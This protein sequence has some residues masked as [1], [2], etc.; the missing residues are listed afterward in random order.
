MTNKTF[1]YL[2]LILFFVSTNV[3]SHAPSQ[4]TDLWHKNSFQAVGVYKVLGK[5]IPIEFKYASSS[6][7]I[8]VGFNDDGNHSSLFL[9][10]KKLQPEG[11]WLTQ[12]ACLAFPMADVAFPEVDLFAQAM[13]L[14]KIPN[15]TSG[16]HIFAT[17]NNRR[18]FV[19]DNDPLLFTL[20]LKDPAP[21]KS[22]IDIP[23]TDVCLNPGAFGYMPK[24]DEDVTEHEKN[25][26][27]KPGRCNLNP[28][29]E[30]NRDWSGGSV[31]H[32]ETPY[33]INLN[34]Y[35][36]LRSRCKNDPDCEPSIRHFD[37][38]NYGWHCGAGRGESD[39]PFISPTDKACEM[40]DRKI[41]ANDSS[42]NWC[43]LHHV[44][45]CRRSQFNGNLWRASDWKVCFPA[46]A[47]ALKTIQTYAWLKAGGCR[48]DLS[49]K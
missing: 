31:A 7:Q 22:G 47:N 30:A 2:Y 9:N 32:V 43:G 8:Y 48:I 37:G 33:R 4:K 5:E 11:K 29:I 15:S 18:I 42:L 20:E 12:Q 19:V 28:W 38:G 35:N 46:D 10:W 27:S 25:S 6:K 41:W 26:V 39:L 34:Q 1:T 17:E 21:L 23:D 40:H 16:V 49:C 45:T 36:S 3:A 24:V 14:P 44:L 13:A